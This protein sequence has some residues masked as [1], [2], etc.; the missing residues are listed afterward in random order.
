MPASNNAEETTRDTTAIEVQFDPV[1][2]E[3]IVDVR[4]A[5]TVQRNGGRLWFCSE[6]C[7]ARFLL[8]PQ[9]YAVSC[10]ELE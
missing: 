2:G 3:E 8:E 4:A 10:V 5:V 7:R 1:C 9:R 6:R